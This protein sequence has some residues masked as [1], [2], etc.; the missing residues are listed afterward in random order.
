MAETGLITRDSFLVLANPDVVHETLAENFG[1]ERLTMGDL[2]K[3]KIPAGGGTFWTVE[4]SEGEQ[5][6][7]EISG[8]IIHQQTQ[9]SYFS[10]PY[11][12]GNEK[13]D[14]SSPD[15]QYGYG[16]PGDGLRAEGNGCA[17]CPLSQ[18][19]SG[20]GGVGQACAQKKVLYVLQPGEVLPT[21]ITLAPS[22]LQNFKR[23]LLRLGITP[24]YG[25]VTSFSLVKATSKSGI[26]YSQVV[27]KV[28][29]RLDREDAEQIKVYRQALLAAM[30]RRNDLNGQAEDEEEWS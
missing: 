27:P 12:G 9:R 10:G 17:E 20:K 8:V 19:G 21:L 3:I 7:K 5:S 11:T 26:G 14:C 18:W 25:V 29:S 15:G 22:S 1:S 2:Q 28:V 30:A 6:V 24:Y 16:D 23:Y 13:P 4:T